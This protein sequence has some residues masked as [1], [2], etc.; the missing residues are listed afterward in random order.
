MSMRSLMSMYAM[1]FAAMLSSLDNPYYMGAYP[2]NPM[3]NYQPVKM[4]GFTAAKGKRKK[5][6]KQ[7]KI[8][9]LK[10]INQLK[11]TKK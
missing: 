7:R 6:K 2:E 5:S 4:G 9:N 3:N 1:G 10:R 8:E 11:N